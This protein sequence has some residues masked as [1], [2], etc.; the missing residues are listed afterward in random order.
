MVPNQCLL[1]VLPAGAAPLLE[2]HSSP[3][4]QVRKILFNLL[5]W[6]T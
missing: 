6:L 2:I 5:W 1:Q 3:A 4:S